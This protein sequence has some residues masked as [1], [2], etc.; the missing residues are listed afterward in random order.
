MLIELASFALGFTDRDNELGLLRQ[1]LY[2]VLQYLVLRALAAK[3][4]RALERV[5]DAYFCHVQNVHPCTAIL[6]F[7]P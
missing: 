5:H 3:K 1:Y 4:G 6:F 2:P 7:F